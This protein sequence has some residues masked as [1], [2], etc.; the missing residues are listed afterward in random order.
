M[1]QHRYEAKHL[2]LRAGDQKRVEY[3]A[4]NSNGYVPTLVHEDFVVC[5]S[6]VIC[7][8]VDDAFPNRPRLT[9]HHAAP[10]CSCRVRL[11]H[12]QDLDRA[13][14]SRTAAA[15]REG[16]LADGSI[17]A[18]THRGDKGELAVVLRA[19]A[20]TLPT[21]ARYPRQW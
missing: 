18:P 15:R 9:R 11:I 20:S 17:L 1:D 16:Q 10:D 19:G 2:D 13:R 4:L 12:L 5:E 21:A 14:L 6:T 8:Y 7:R 3:L